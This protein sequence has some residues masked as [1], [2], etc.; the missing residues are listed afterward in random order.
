MRLIEGY[1]FVIFIGVFVAA[2]ELAYLLVGSFG[3]V[4]G[5][6]HSRLW[7][8]GRNHGVGDG[9]PN[10]FAK[11]AASFSHLNLRVSFGA[12]HSSTGF[13]AF[14]SNRRGIA[15]DRKSVV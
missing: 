9:F 3:S 1:V 10:F 8:V 7:L 2:A 12:E 6:C 5:A 4:C 14:G 13:I 15:L 11:R